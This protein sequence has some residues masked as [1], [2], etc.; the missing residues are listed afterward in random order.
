MIEED[1]RRLLSDVI[2]LCYFTVTVNKVISDSHENE[3]IFVSKYGSLQK[4]SGNFKD[5]RRYPLNVIKEA[6][7]FLEIL[8]IGS[9][10]FGSPFIIT[11]FLVTT[12]PK[13]SYVLRKLFIHPNK[14]GEKIKSFPQINQL[15]NTKPHYNNLS[16]SNIKGTQREPKRHLTV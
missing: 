10:L 2:G 9:P 16:K 7:Y 8:F 3:I 15:I 6:D 4:P 11:L 13:L 14:N 1:S 12:T 5:F